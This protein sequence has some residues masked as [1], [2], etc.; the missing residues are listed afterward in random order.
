MG[1]RRH[2]RRVCGFRSGHLSAVRS[3]GRVVAR[4]RDRQAT[5]VATERAC[6]RLVYSCRAVGL[7]RIGGARSGSA[8]P[9]PGGASPSALRSERFVTEQATYTL[10]LRSGPLGSRYTVATPP[11]TWGGS[12]RRRAA[13][14]RRQFELPHRVF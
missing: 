11:E 9:R 5:L 2:G 14:S 8:R 10:A 3:P 7:T 4:Q 13:L 6:T 1:S 12:V